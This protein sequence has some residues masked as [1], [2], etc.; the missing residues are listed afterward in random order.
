[1]DIRALA[2]FVAKEPTNIYKN[3]VQN[4]SLLG[5]TPNRFKS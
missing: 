4:L 5:S 3:K 2:S 1:M